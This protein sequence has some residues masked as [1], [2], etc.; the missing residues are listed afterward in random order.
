MISRD[1]VVEPDP[2][3]DDNKNDDKIEIMT[4][5]IRYFLPFPIFVNTFLIQAA[6]INHIQ[7][8]D[9]RDNIKKSKPG[10]RKTG[11]FINVL[12]QQPFYSAD[13]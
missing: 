9:C 6:L 7:P 12:W 5:L 13:L 11:A 3:G 8:K 10:P 1:K 2:A 4:L